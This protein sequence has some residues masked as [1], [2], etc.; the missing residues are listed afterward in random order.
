MHGKAMMPPS[1]AE[2]RAQRE[3]VEILADLHPDRRRAG[4]RPERRRVAG[5]GRVQAVHVDA[6]VV[7]DQ[8]DLWIQVPVDAQGPDVLHAAADAAHG[9]G[10]TLE[11]RIVVEVR[12]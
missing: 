4:R 12:A 8:A 11:P 2:L 6:Q 5:P 7:E 10:R 3:Y 9:T 1:E